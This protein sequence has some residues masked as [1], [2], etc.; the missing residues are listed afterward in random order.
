MSK[1]TTSQYGRVYAALKMLKLSEEDKKDMV[2]SYTQDKMKLSLKDLDFDQCSDLI[3]KLNKMVSPS[4]AVT[5]P[6]VLGGARGGKKGVDEDKEAK[7]RIRR[8]I[9][10]LCHNLGWYR[11]NEVKQ[12]DYARMDAYCLEHTGAKKELN[13]MSKEELQKAAYQF[14][15][16]Y[17]N[18]ITQTKK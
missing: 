12:L 2:F 4:S 7:N 16:M 10:A 11:P 3:Q 5:S 13:K 8:R 14:D 6:P 15:Q 17:K 18:Y 9:L 1:S